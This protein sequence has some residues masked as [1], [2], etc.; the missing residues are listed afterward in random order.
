MLYRAY[1]WVTMECKEI[2]MPDY[3]PIDIGPFCNAGGALYG[4]G[5]APPIGQLTFHGL[6]FLIGGVAP[7]PEQCFVA[8]GSGSA[9]AGIHVPIGVAA[10]HVLFAHALLDSRLLENGPIG[11]VVAHYS[12]RYA[13]G[14]IVRIPVR[15]RFEIA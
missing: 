6:P 5:A 9:D 12:V 11:E 13:N 10:R 8:L 3:Q 1:S 15:E 14:E 4:P 7:N 2:R